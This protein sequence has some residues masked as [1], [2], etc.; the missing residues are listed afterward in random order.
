MQ[1][2]TITRRDPKLMQYAFDEAKRRNPKA[3]ARQLLDAAKAIYT[4]EWEQS[5]SKKVNE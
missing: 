4:E 5:R 3:K 2:N 1:S